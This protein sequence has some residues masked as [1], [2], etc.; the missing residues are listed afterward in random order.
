MSDDTGENRE[1]PR[2]GRGRPFLPGNNANPAGR[3]AGYAAFRESFRGQTDLD[4]IQKRLREIMASG[5]DK[6][7]TSA[8]RLWMEYGWGKPSSSPED[9]EATTASPFAGM[10]AEQLLEIARTKK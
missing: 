4:V 6:D 5:D 1:K 10:T 9:L 8:M 7:A 2:R 3:P